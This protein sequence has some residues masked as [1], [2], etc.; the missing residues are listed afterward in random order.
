MSRS[1]LVDTTGLSRVTVGQRLNELFEHRLI[2]EA[3]RTKSSGGRPTRPVTLNQDAGLIAV[4]DLGETHVHFG[5]TD[6]D[7]RLLIEDTTA[8]D[9]RQPPGETLDLISDGIGDLMSRLGGDGRRLAGLGLSLPAPV[10]FQAATVEGPSVMTGWDNFDIRGH[11]ARRLPVPVMVDNDV[12]LLAIS[13]VAG[14][15]D[16]SAQIVF[17]KVGTG[18]GC[19]II[20]DGLVFRGANGAAG[21][22][23]HMQLTAEPDK[24]CRCGKLGCVEAVAGG[25]A[26][27]RDLRALGIEA[28][29]ARDVA[30]LVRQNVPEAIQ[31]VRRAGRVVG[32]VVASLVSVLN[33]GRIVVGGMMAE[34]GEHL[35]SGVR[36]IVYQRCLSLATRDLTIS[37]APH[38]PSA[39]LHGAALLVRE[40]IFTPANVAETTIRL[41]SPPEAARQSA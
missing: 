17:I 9:I 32:E 16:R 36:E 27:A 18:I 4:A 3:E 21:D 41:L 1:D 35:L 6:L 12:N 19:G 39:G 26:I 22:V 5:L 23:G 13:T 38:D 25:W 20:A 2:V 31:L 15:Q 7:A 40:T 11:L 14:M 33:P 29:T 28:E 37:M 8:F 24:L 34:T 10:N 30:D